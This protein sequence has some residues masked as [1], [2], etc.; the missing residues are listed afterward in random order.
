[1]RFEWDEEGCT[2][3]T[4]AL[5]G[6]IPINFRPWAKL[7]TTDLEGRFES[8]VMADVACGP[9]FLCTE[10]AQLN[11]DYRFI[12]LDSNEPMM[13]I[14]GKEM[15]EAG[16]DAETITCP[17][18]KLTLPDG[19]VDA[20]TCKQYFH[21]ADDPAA[22]IREFFRVL[23]GGGRVFLIDFDSEASRMPAQAVRLLLRAKAGKRISD[24]YWMNFNRG[25]AGSE[26][27][28]HTKAAGFADVHLKRVG[29]N[30]FITA[31]KP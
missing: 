31:T 23:K 4:E 8:P 30:Y 11:P 21:E 7:I 29:P 25:K 14:A 2:Y 6:T 15:E 27:I 13:T 28:E 17:A 9:G 10:T 24:W 5:R 26:M 18:D 12:L 3:Y 20:L 1:M 16:I 19:H 22:V